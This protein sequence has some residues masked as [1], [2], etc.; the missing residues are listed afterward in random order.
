MGLPHAEIVGEEYH[1]EFAALGCA[2]DFEIML[3]I[4]AGIGLRTRMPPRRDMMAGR[5]E[6]GAEPHLAFAAHC[7]PFADSTHEIIESGYYYS[8]RGYP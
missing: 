2:C 8:A 5:I 7:L 4:D 6:E 1:V 3:E